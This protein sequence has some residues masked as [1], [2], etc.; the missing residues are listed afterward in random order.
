L[1]RRLALLAQWCGVDLAAAH[2]GA[3][4][5]AP[6]DVAVAARVPRYRPTI[7]RGAPLIYPNSRVRA[8]RGTGEYTD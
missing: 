2:Y 4:T 1:L 8:A 7:D 5:A 6:A 3:L